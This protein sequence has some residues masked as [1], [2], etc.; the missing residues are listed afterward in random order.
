[1]QVLS[2]AVGGVGRLLWTWWTS[3]LKVGR[4]CVVE[5]KGG[6]WWKFMQWFELVFFPGFGVLFLYMGR[7][8]WGFIVGI[9]KVVE[10]CTWLNKI[11]YLLRWTKFA[12][13]LRFGQQTWCT[14]LLED[15]RIYVISVECLF[16]SKVLKVDYNLRNLLWNHWLKHELI[17]CYLQVWFRFTLLFGKNFKLSSI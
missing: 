3:N 17:L 6:A 12:I 8:W 10:L 7:I 1:M 5:G 13:L 4:W 15:W 16:L 2:R 14:F 9:L 11:F